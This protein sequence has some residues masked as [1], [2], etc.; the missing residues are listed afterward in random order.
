MSRVLRFQSALTAL[1]RDPGCTLAQVATGS[2]YFD[3]AHFVKEFRRLSGGVP[4]GYRG[5]FPPDGPD[6]FKPNVVVFLQD[7][8]SGDR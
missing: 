6:D 4:R 3:Q 7:G 5:Y 1:M 2:G 8:T